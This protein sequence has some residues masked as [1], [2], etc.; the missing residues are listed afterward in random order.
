MNRTEVKHNPIKRSIWSIWDSYGIYIFLALVMVV[1]TL[2][3]DVVKNGGVVKFLAF[4]NIIN[5]LSNAVPSAVCA[6]AMTFCITAGAFDLSVGSVSTLATVVAGLTLNTMAMANP[7]INPGLLLFCALGLV[8]VVAVL[9]GLLNG[10]LITTLKI[11][12]FVTTLGTMLL[13]RGIAGRVAN[14]NDFSIGPE[15]AKAAQVFKV[16][17]TAMGGKLSILIMVLIFAVAYALYRYTKFGINSRAIGSNES[18]AGISGIPVK[19]TMVVIFILTALLAALAGVFYSSRLMTGSGNLN[20][21]FELSVI[22]ATILGGTALSGG[23]GNV[24]GSMI[25]AILLWSVQSG[26]NLLGVSDS[27]RALVVGFIL[28]LSL[29]IGGL[30]EIT[31]AKEVRG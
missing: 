4:E 23:K 25:A 16:I 26:C 12:A 1:F 30:R 15:R 22:T 17:S 21:G 24:L 14:G 6:A 2:L 31:R 8:A 28:L 10:V 19:R 27:V 7:A 13:Y 20:N 5:I 3:V 18:S 29:S 11:P 9:C